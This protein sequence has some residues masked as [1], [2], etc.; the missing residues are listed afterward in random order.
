MT[1]NKYSPPSG[2]NLPSQP[3][4]RY[5][6]E[7][8]LYVPACMGIAPAIM[9]A[10]QGF[11]GDFASIFAGF[12]GLTVEAFFRGDKGVSGTTGTGVSAWANQSGVATGMTP[13]SGATNGVGTATV[14]NNNHAALKTD[15]T[16]QSG[17][18]NLAGVAP[19]TSNNNIWAIERILVTPT[20]NGF[21]HY[22]LALGPGIYLPGS[23]VSPAAN[24]NQYNHGATNGPTTGVVINQWYRIKSSWTN[25]A[26]TDQLRVGSHVAP[27][28]AT[29]NTAP[30]A[31]RGWGSLS[32]GTGKVSVETCALVYVKGPVA[33]FNIASNFADSAAQSWFAGVQY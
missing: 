24:M 11:T 3:Y 12:T 20:G 25:N 26:A 18:F 14:G 4:S 33:T 27:Q 6:Y 30:T 17:T 22:D 28:L 2:Y 13:T 19:G 9:P 15:G 32:D 5:S 8:G 21:L 7:N 23:Q 1:Y 29:D 16:T 31:T 10:G